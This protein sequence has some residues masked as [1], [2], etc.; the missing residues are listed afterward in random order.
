M[1]HLRYHVIREGGRRLHNP[2]TS[3]QLAALG[4]TLR[5][6]KGERVLDLGS[7]SG[8]LLCTWARD[9]GI[10]GTGVDICDE[11]TDR[12]GARAVELGVDGLVEFVRGDASE[13]IADEP[14]D[15]ACCLGAS[16]IGGGAAGTAELLR[17]SLRPGGTVLLGEPFW[18][19]EPPDQRS[20]EACHADD[21][22][23]FPTLPE[24]LAYFGELGYDVVGMTI[25]DQQGWDRYKSA[26]WLS[27]RR[28]LT[29]HPDDGLAAR[30]RAELAEE[31]AEYA[32]HERE[33]LGWGVFAL[34][35]R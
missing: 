14:V 15:L 9:H 21:A 33:Y 32:R 24:L 25:A 8:E 4:R 35:A 11:F 31:P 18:R 2:L 29:R 12:A 34:M 17:R 13:Y 23:D 1:D 10:T 6:E 27:M 30:L 20:V 28:W 19:R 3:D 16:W 22:D 5:L 26:Q 7:G